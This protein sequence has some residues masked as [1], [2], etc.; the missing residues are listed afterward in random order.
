MREFQQFK[1]NGIVSNDTMRAIDKNADAYNVSS[2]QRMESAGTILAEHLRILQ[3]DSVLFL[4]GLGNNGGDGFV[5]ARHMANFAD[6]CVIACGEPKT[7]DAK[8]AFSALK[9]TPV[10]IFTIRTSSEIPEKAFDTDIIVDCLLGTGAKAPLKEPYE[11]LVK[12][13]NNSKAYVISC[14]LPTPS[15][16]TDKVIAF[17]LP[18]SDGAV[19]SDIGIPLAAEVF[20]GDGDLMIIPQKKTDAHKGAGGNIL[21]VGGGPYQ[22]APFLSGLAALRSGADVVRIAAPVNGFAPD[23]ILER[24]VGDHVSNE[25]LEKLLSLAEKSDVVVCGPGLGTNPESLAAAS[26][27]VRASRKA[28]VDA[29]LLRSPLP[30]A[31]NETIYTPHA[32]EFE[33]CFTALP[34]N[35][36]ERGCA[37]RNAAKKSR[38][39]IVLKGETDIIS[40]GSRVKFNPSGA[41][42]MTVGG[43]GDVLSGVCGALLARTGSFEAACAAVYAVCKAGCACDLETGDGLIATD[44]L[45]TLSHILYKGENDA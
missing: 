4:C 2:S 23:L 45:K 44:L 13:M 6:V 39:T 40:N 5:A 29:D 33:R 41:K 18:K 9:A 31:Q 20:C 21:I 38:A 8:R 16:R 37:V 14:D 30:L 7:E 1:L 35:I 22:G 17:H 42:S 19:V 32:G 43:T 25:H 28:V 24:L 11:S 34:K 26:E 15:A 3:P 10:D 27:V 12:L 36:A